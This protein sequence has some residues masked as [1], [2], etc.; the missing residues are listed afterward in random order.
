VVGADLMSHLEG[1]TSQRRPH[2]CHFPDEGCP[3]N[4]L[5]ESLLISAVVLL[6]E[7]AVKAVIRQVK[8]ALLT[9]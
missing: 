4:G 8:P 7:L 9:V 2:H 5:L 3:M 6:L 1:G